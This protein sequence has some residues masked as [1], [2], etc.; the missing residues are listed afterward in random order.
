MVFPGG[1]V[2]GGARTSLSFVPDQRMMLEHGVDVG[3]GDFQPLQGS[4]PCSAP[5]FIETS[6]MTSGTP[7]GLVT[8]K[9]TTTSDVPSPKGIDS[10]LE[11]FSVRSRWSLLVPLQI[12]SHRGAHHRQSHRRG[13]PKTVSTLIS[14][15]DHFSQLLNPPAGGHNAAG[16]RH[17]HRW[18]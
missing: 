9:S 13:R 2:S 6:R 5:C 4:L 8:R 3:P 16:S 18:P 12:S 7:D 11:E 17:Y 14:L 1:I 15:L 10:N